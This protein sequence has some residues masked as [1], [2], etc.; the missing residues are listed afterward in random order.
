MEKLF[1][2][3]LPYSASESDLQALVES[4]GFPVRRAAVIYDRETNR[5]RGFGFVE[6]QDWQRTMEAA[7]AMQSAEMSSR[8]LTVNVAERKRV[9]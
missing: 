8:R 2:G 1:V 5:S 4:Y 7:Q 3:N 9:A 6:L